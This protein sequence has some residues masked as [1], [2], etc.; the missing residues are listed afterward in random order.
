MSRPELLTGHSPFSKDLLLSGRP[1]LQAICDTARRSFG[2]RVVLVGSLRVAEAEQMSIEA[3]SNEEIGVEISHYDICVAPCQ[4]AVQE[5]QTVVYLGGLETLYPHDEGI[6]AFD[7]RS[8][9]GCPLIDAEGQTIG[10]IVMEWDRSLTREEA[11]AAVAAIEALAPRV[12]AEVTGLILTQALEVLARP[13]ERGDEGEVGIFFTIADQA[14]SLAQVRAAFVAQCH[15]Q[16]PNHFRIIASVLDGELQPQHEGKVYGYDGTPCEALRDRD[17]VLIERGLPELFR[18]NDYF[19]ANNLQSYFGIGFRGQDGEPI[20]HLALMHERPMSDRIARSEIL[21]AVASRAK[22]ELKRFIAESRRKSLEDGLQVRKKLESLGLMAGSIAH[23]FN[24]QLAAMI[25]HTE[26]AIADL[27]PQHPACE[28][29]KIAEKSMWQARDVISGLMDF[30]GGAPRGG[31]EKVALNSVVQ[32]E[33]APL[34]TRQ[35]SVNRIDLELDPALPMID[36]RVAQL[37]QIVSNVVNNA[38]EA[39]QDAGGTLSVRTAAVEIPDDE[40]DRC[41]TGHGP[42]MRGH[43]VML[44]VHDNGIGMDR[45]TAERVFEPFFSTKSQNR[46]LG[47]A[48]VLGIAKRMNAS[49]TLI[50]EPRWGT[51]IRFYFRVSET[52]V[53]ASGSADNGKG[54]RVG[55]SGIG[56]ILVVDDEP[57]VLDAVAQHVRKVGYTVLRATSGEEAAAV[58]CTADDLKAAVIDVLMPGIDGWET[59]RMLRVERGMLPAL[60]ISGYDHRGPDSMIRPDSRIQFLAKPFRAEDLQHQLTKLLRAE[61]AAI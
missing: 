8:Y 52:P 50:S 55:R 60:M 33:L 23:D 2:P 19:A 28:S 22:Q 11:D 53:L 1:A 9:V 5:Q 20:G 37:H 16:D 49:L 13:L 14:A 43:C 40:R 7:S 56:A 46:G 44:E 57:S 31:T 26:L 15:D 6:K 29:L 47:L 42:T 59:L 3:I 39:M 54:R 21:G 38:T 48:G 4:R 18:T 45:A 12:S 58:A 24:N 36:G 10:I 30:A 34:E 32:Q 51:R 61:E 25:G 35:N 17:T 41:L 27:H